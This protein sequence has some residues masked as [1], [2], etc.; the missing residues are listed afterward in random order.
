MGR[1]YG[2]PLELQ[3]SS[4][5]IYRSLGM[6]GFHFIY[7]YL[8]FRGSFWMRIPPPFLVLQRFIQVLLD[9][10]I[11]YR[12]RR[13]PRSPIEAYDAQWLIFWRIASTRL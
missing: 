10:D 5:N 8:W 6:D 2:R 9:I 7:F 3:F 12:S 11:P 4:Q 1:I 13:P